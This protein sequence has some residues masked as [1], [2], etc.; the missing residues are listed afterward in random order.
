MRATG[1]SRSRAYRLLARG[2]L[3]FNV[4]AGTRYIRSKDIGD[5]IRSAKITARIP[6]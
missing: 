2:I 4:F 6:S 5:F 1:I 3:L